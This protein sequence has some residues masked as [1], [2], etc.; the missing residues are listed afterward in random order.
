MISDYRPVLQ[1][2][3]SAIIDRPNDTPLTIDLLDGGFGIVALPQPLPSTDS[4]MLQVL[5]GL[6]MMACTPPTF[7][8]S[9]PRDDM[10]SR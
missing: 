2:E 7:Y 1:A 3:V 9:Q 5:M 4:F 8:T 6:R 10:E